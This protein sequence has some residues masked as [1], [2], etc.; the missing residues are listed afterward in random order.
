MSGRPSSPESRC[1]ERVEVLLPTERREAVA[2]DAD[3]L[4]RHALADLGLVARLGE[5]HEAAVAVQ[6]DEAGRD[7][8]S[9]GV[10][11]RAGVLRS[12]VARV[13]Q[14]HPVAFDDD[15]AGPGRRAGP[16]DD[17]AADDQEVDAVR[18]VADDTALEPRGAPGDQIRHD[19]DRE[20]PIDARLTRI[21][22]QR[23]QSRSPRV[24]TARVGPGC[25]SAVR[26][27]RDVGR[28]RAPR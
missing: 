12:G 11:G 15:R 3:D 16:I 7:D 5:D 1:D 18:H 22:H 28:C 10:D 13:E 24:R 20:R 8:P 27:R 23:P 14:A 6:V 25:V 21:A 2:V 4:G 17:G 9:G 19:A 26:R